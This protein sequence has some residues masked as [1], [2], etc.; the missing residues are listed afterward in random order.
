MTKWL[1]TIFNANSF[2]VLNLTC[3][4]YDSES[5]NKELKGLNPIY[6]GLA[7]L[8]LTHCTLLDPNHN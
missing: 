3:L 7:A 2:R 1:S 4:I 6:T 5:N 8:G